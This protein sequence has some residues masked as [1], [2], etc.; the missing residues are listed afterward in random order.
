MR[1]R[2]AGR[3]EGDSGIGEDY[4]KLVCPHDVAFDLKLTELLR[5]L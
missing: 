2:R 5:R 3:R 1:P 4:L